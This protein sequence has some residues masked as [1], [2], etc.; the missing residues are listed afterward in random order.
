MLVWEKL[1]KGKV[2]F[3]N[4][5]VSSTITYWFGEQAGEQVSEQASEH[6]RRGLITISKTLTTF[7][8]KSSSMWRKT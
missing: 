3:T 6:A 1:T 8:Q 2:E 4:D 5:L 7:N